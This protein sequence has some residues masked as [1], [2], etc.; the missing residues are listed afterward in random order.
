MSLGSC[1]AYL[2]LKSYREK[3]YGLFYLTLIQHNRIIVREFF[4]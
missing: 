4:R 3:I 1:Q 2:L